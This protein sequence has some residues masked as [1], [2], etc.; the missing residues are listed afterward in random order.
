ML[1]CVMPRRII[2]TRV[3]AELLEA[4]NLRFGQL[5]GKASYASLSWA[6]ETGMRAALEASAGNPAFIDKVKQSIKDHI[7]SVK[8]LPRL[9]NDQPSASGA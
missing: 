9:P 4:Y 1:N 2:R 8:H 6:L 3:D 7:S 5:D